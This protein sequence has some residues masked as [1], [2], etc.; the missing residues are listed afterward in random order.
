M[1]EV[2]L[3]ERKPELPN[4][5]GLEQHEERQRIRIHKIHPDIAG[6]QPERRGGRRLQALHQGFAQRWTGQPREL[7]SPVPC[8]GLGVH[9]IALRPSA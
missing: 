8:A 5:L 1:R 6:A 9:P 2:A 4:G 7:G 3:A